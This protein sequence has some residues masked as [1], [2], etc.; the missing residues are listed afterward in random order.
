LALDA[1]LEAAFDR[2][3]HAHLLAQLRSFPA[4]GMTRLWLQ[5]GVID[6]GRFASTLEGTPG[7]HRQPGAGEHRPARHGAGR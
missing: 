2:I 3:G 1:D 4:R 7:R 5:A 6:N